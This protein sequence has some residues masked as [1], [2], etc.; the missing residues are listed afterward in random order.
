MMHWMNAEGLNFSSAQNEK[1]KPQYDFFDY[2]QP[3]LPQKNYE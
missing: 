3:Y 2:K 1:T